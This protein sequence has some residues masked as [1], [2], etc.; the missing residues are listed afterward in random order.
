M[1]PSS[2]QSAERTARS[3]PLSWVNSHPSNSLGRFSK[4][5]FLFAQATAPSLNSLTRK[6]LPSTNTSRSSA[7][8]LASNHKNTTAAMSTLYLFISSSFR[9]MLNY[10]GFPIWMYLSRSRYWNLANC[11]NMRPRRTIHADSRSRSTPRSRPT[12]CPVTVSVHPRFST[13]PHR[14]SWFW[15]STIGFSCHIGMKLA[16]PFVFKGLAQIAC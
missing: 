2:R 1:T 5:Y 9:S 4:T 7:P 8:A 12:P 6:P 11:N 16:K 15:Q 14:K 13:T 10:P 3:P